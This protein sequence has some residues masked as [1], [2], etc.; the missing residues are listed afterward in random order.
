MADTGYMIVTLFA[1]EPFA[2]DGTFQLPAWTLFTY[3]NEC[4]DGR[5]RGVLQRGG[6]LGEL[7][8]LHFKNTICPNKSPYYY[9]LHKKN[10]WFRLSTLKWCQSLLWNSINKQCYALA[11]LKDSPENTI[12]TWHS[13]LFTFILTCSTS[14][15]MSD[16]QVSTLN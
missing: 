3:S 4:V 5:R 16:G 8:G 10:R 12:Y 14:V 7:M 11:Y 13:K 15:K 1:T 6:L 2:N 9:L